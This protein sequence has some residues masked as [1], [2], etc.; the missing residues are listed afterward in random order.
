MHDVIIYPDHVDANWR[1]EAGHTLTP[2]DLWEVLRSPP[3]VLVIGQ[4]SMGRMKVPAATWQQLQAA[5]ITIMAE[6][7]VRACETYNRLCEQ[8]RVVAAL[9]LTC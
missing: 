6:P 5:G 9:H 8:R 4:G 3:E 1:R 2:E 7:T